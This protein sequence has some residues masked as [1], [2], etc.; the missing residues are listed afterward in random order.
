MGLAPLGIHG[1][2]EARPDGYQRTP[3]SSPR[4]SRPEA[5]VLVVASSPA[6]HFFTIFGAAIAGF[7]LIFGL[8]GLI[9]RRASRLRGGTRT[10][11]TIVGFDARTTGS[12]QIPGSEIGVTG[13]T[14]MGPGVV[15]RPTVQFRT[16]HGTNVTVLYDPANP[17][18][19][20]VDTAT[21]RGTCLEVAF[22]LFG[23][24]FAALGII[25]LIASR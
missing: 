18:R 13:M 10:R 11:G 17:Q 25:I 16:A 23:G 24:A 6:Q 22:M 9:I 14:G 4:Y 19:V 8:V 7:G 15:Y 5:A 3:G 20:R 2:G 21:G 1:A 12:M